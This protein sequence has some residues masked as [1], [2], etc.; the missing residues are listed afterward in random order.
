MNNLPLPITL[1]S[2][3]GDCVTII[4]MVLT[5]RMELQQ[6]EPTVAEKAFRFCLRPTKIVRFAQQK[7][8]TSPNGNCALHPMPFAQR[9]SCTLCKENCVL[10]STEIGCF[11]QQKLGASPNV[12]RISLFVESNCS[13][14]VCFAQRASEIVCYSQRST[15]IVCFAQRP[16]PCNANCVLHIDL[17]VSRGLINMIMS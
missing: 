9:K 2:M 6:F 3:A 10:C 7:L 4:E 1:F 14:A 11:P 13:C 15:E 8:C 12:Q 17:I 5:V 16:S